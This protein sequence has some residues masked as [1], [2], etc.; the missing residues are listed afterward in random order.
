MGHIF[1]PKYR[2]K[3]TDA[4]RES[5]V[6]WIKYYRNGKPYRESTKSVKEADAKR[7]LK[8]REGE[9]ATG[10]LPG[11]YFDK[12]KFDELVDDITTDYV[13][14][15]R[16]MAG[17]NKRLKHLKP[18]LEG[19]RASDIT[20]TGINAYIM[21]RLE[22]G[23]ANATINRELA[24]LKRM[25]N[26]G[27][28]QT[29]PKVDRVPHFPMLEENN[30]RKGF[31]EH[32]DF[33]SLREKLPEYLQGFVTFGYQTGMRISEITN[34]TWEKVDL[35][36]GVVR[37]EPG[38]TKNDDA[39]TVY[40][41]SELIDMLKQ[42]RENRKVSGK[43]CPYVF[44]NEKGTSKIANIKKAWSKAC[45]NCG[46]GYGY[47]LTGKYVNKWRDKLP[48]GPLFHDFRRTAVRN[49]DRAGISRVV[50]MK[51]S[52]HKTESV[53]N[54]YNIV[55]DKD[56]QD[57]ARKMEEYLLSMTGKVTGKVN[58]FNEK[59]VNRCTS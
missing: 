46:L 18:A 58:D 4:V 26:L 36:L 39:R 24:A 53:Y 21:N 48:A 40:L 11:I 49:M 16:D 31:F 28:K 10:K 1:K 34:L 3:K 7:L 51:R 22:E 30:V 5:R 33:L 54:R 56:M 41:S 8:K 55:D 17:L 57:A 14:N 59:R 45:R 13:I 27:A 32:G 6:Y 25:L 29:P 38:E 19:M 50:A 35:G 43:V 15:G 23:A 37:L 42:Q 44:P 12:I 2:D 9:V 20:T 52:G 47:K